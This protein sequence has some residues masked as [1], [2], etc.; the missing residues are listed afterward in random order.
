MVVVLGVFEEG[1][2]D[3]G[4]D[5]TSQYEVMFLL[6]WTTGNIRGTIKC[7]VY[8][9]CPGVLSAVKR[10]RPC[11]RSAGITCCW[12]YAAIDET[13]E[14]DGLEEETFAIDGFNAVHG[15]SGKKIHGMTAQDWEC[16]QQV[17]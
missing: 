4:E 12:R 5:V 7:E 1:A 13:P 17:Q 16:T 11:V 6:W 2:G 9:D 14:C 8:P 3:G 15:R 10:R